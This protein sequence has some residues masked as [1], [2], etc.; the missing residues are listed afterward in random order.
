MHVGRLAANKR[1]DLLLRVLPRL[2]QQW[3]RIQLALVGEGPEL[4]PLRNLAQ[5]LAIADIVHF[6]GPITDHKLLAPWVLASDLMIAPAQIGLFA[7][8]SLVYGRTLVISDVPEHRGPEV[9]AFVPGQTGL[10]YKYE[11]EDD[12]CHVITDLL[13]DPEKR[14]KFA[15]AGSDRVRE[16][17]GTRGMLHA[18]LAAIRYVHEGYRS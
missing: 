14:K 10:T 1:L 18:F 16:L 5:E 17:M 11:D 3:P 12:L 15:K 2:R 8:M 9:Q 6:L 13:R 4:Q 7:P